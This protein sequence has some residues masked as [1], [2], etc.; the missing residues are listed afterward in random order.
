MLPDVPTIQSKPRRGTANPKHL[1]QA[2][3]ETHI[4]LV[5]H[6][7]RCYG[8]RVKCQYLCSAGPWG[9]HRCSKPDGRSGERALSSG[10]NMKRNL[11]QSRTPFLKYLGVVPL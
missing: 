8:E 10:A 9:D 3:A 6:A 7:T 2:P 5:P 4:P 11:S 1:T